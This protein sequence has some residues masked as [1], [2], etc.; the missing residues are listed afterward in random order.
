MAI[1][2]GTTPTI[3]YTFKTVTPSTISTA[4]LTVRQGQNSMDRGTTVFELTKTDM[5]TG[6]D[7]VSFKLTQA[8]TLLLKDGI[9]CDIQ[10]RYKTSDGTAYATLHAKEDVIDI[11]KEGAI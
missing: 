4:Y 8:Q 1:I 2:R 10:F 7:Y 6:T 5:T 9:P 3:K 11:N